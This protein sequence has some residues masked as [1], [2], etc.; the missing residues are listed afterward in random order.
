MKM[1]KSLF[2]LQRSEK[3]G[4]IFV[5]V[6]MHRQSSVKTILRNF[7]LISILGRISSPS[8]SVIVQSSTKLGFSLVKN[9]ETRT[10]APNHTLFKQTCLENP[11]KHLVPKETTP[12]N[13]GSPLNP[14]TYKISTYHA[15]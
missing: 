14:T 5:F 1:L 11:L 10:H 15:H 7:R 4:S 9:L 12:A 3:G 2:L 6:L 8:M 13:Q